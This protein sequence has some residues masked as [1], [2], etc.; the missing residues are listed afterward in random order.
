MIGKAHPRPVMARLQ[1]RFDPPDSGWIRLQAQPL[2]ADWHIAATHLDDPFPAMMDWLETILDGAA[3]ARWAIEEEGSVA[4]FVFLASAG[5][6]TRPKPQL[7]FMSSNDRGDVFRL[8][9]TP[10]TPLELVRTFYQSFRE[11][12]EGPGYVADEWALLDRDP[13]EWLWHGDDLRA[14]RSRR[15]EEALR[16]PLAEQLSLNLQHR[17]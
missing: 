7:V 2:T 13:E 8:A 4:Q 17:F 5:W 6:L 14:L 11:Y 3:S 10:V 9:S 15:V 16:A 12:V 1:I